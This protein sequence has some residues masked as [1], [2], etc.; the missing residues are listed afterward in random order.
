MGYSNDVVDYTRRCVRVDR[1]H[2][3]IVYGSD[4]GREDTDGQWLAGAP[5]PENYRFDGVYNAHE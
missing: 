4:T 2:S 3:V 1:K 5:M